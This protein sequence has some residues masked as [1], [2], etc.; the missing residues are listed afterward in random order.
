MATLRPDLRI[1]FSR[2]V[3]L[4]KAAIITAQVFGPPIIR[5]QVAIFDDQDRL[6]GGVGTGQFGPVRTSSADGVARWLFDVPPDA[7][8]IKWGVQAM[9]SAGGLGGSYSVSGKIWDEQGVE[10]ASGR[11]GSEIP[12]GAF[13]DDFIYDGVNVVVETTPADVV[14]GARL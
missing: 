13:A 9:R 5:M 11:F 2:V 1:N 8:Y 4:R 6:I 7:A 3:S 14:A 12:D 10:L